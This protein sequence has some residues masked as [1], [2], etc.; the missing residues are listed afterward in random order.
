MA[1]VRVVEELVLDVQIV[2][3]V[4]VDVNRVVDAKVDVVEFAVVVVVRVV[5]SVLLGVLHIV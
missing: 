4:P 1:N 3:D 5:R 2:P